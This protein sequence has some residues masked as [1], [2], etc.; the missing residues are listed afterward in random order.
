MTEL[1][2]VG[3]SLLDDVEPLGGLVAVTD[4]AGRVLSALG[5]RGALRRGEQ[6]NLAPWSAWSEQATGTNGMGT[7]LEDPGGVLVRRTEHWCEGLRD[8]SCAGTTI[9][10][11]ATGQPLAVLDVSSW[12]SP[13]PDTVLP[14]LRRAVR[15]IERDLRKRACRDA[16]GLR[17]AFARADRPDASPLV[18]MDAGG[19][20][21]A[22][23]HKGEAL[24][25]G[26]GLGLAMDY[27]G[28][29]GIRP[30]WH[31]AGQ[32]GSIMG[33]VRGAVH[34]SGRRHRAAHH[35]AGRGRQPGRRR[36]RHA[37]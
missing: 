16:D 14:W 33:G 12:R 21:V 22:V 25:G 6:S 37:G 19:A 8:W 23:N 30:A 11:P 20:V 1:G 9:R 13:L 36:A 35:Q 17:A 15:G 31:L 29:A 27:A 18:A 32:G 7:A 2:S 26:S 3:R 24:A 28:A 4:G 5:D 34:P 10:D